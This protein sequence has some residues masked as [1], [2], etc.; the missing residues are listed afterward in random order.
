M[1]LAALMA[2]SMARLTASFPREAAERLAEVPTVVLDPRFSATASV[3]EVYIPTAYAGIECGG[4]AYRMDG[5]PLRL[6]KLVDPPPGVYP[7]EVVLRDVLREV[8]RS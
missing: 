7:D 5:V 6:K 1:A 2:D 3:A 8:L 4:S